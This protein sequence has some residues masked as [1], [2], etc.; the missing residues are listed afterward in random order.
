M[1]LLRCGCSGCIYG[2][3]YVLIYFSRMTKTPPSTEQATSERMMWAL[4]VRPISKLNKFIS[5]YSKSNS[6]DGSLLSRCL[7]ISTVMQSSFH[8][9]AS[10]SIA[11]FSSSKYFTNEILIASHS[12][13]NRSPPNGIFLL[14]TVAMQIA[15]NS[16]EMQSQ[17]NPAWPP[18]YTWAIAQALTPQQL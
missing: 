18:R 2:F 8:C 9:F 16:S 5:Q 11:F 4:N 17:R 1:L 7:T 10:V 13:R 6:R 12:M 3:G 15:G 14:F